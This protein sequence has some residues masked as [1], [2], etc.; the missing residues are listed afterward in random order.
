MSA[1]S[2]ECYS[3]AGLLHYAFSLATVEQACLWAMQS[4]AD[5]VPFTPLTEYLP[6]LG[7]TCLLEAPVYLAA[8]WKRWKAFLPALLLCN[9]ATHPLVHYAFPEL[10]PSFGWNYAAI[11]TVAEIFAPLTE[12]ALLIAVWKVKWP[13]AIGLMVVGNLFSWWVGIH[14]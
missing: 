1:L 8:T 12:A 11:L 2:P 10:G 5:K 4:V 3:P 14:L 9:L 6:V 7:L 13:K